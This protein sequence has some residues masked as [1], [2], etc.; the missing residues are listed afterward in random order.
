MAVDKESLENLDFFK[1]LS[2]KVLGIIAEK[3]E[4]KYVSA[5]EVLFLAGDVS[6]SLYA[7]NK[8][9]IEVYKNFDGDISL[10]FATLSEGDIFGEMALLDEFPRSAS[11]KTLEDC[12]F[13]TLSKDSYDE[14][15]EKHPSEALEFLLQI[16]K[17]L[18]LRI[19]KTNQN[20]E[21]YYFLCRGLIT[22]DK[23]REIY[24]SIIT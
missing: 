17:V 9:S 15:I 22:S 5:G 7:I 12:E 6:S 11:I 13:L 21:D 2:P 4:K 3:V 24:K 8:G 14:I 10:S 18:T 19:R 23:F 20:L 1:S 16:T